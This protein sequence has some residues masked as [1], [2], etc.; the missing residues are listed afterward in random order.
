M[1]LDGA[2]QVAET[3]HMTSLFQLPSSLLIGVPIPEA[4]HAAGDELQLAVDQAVKESIENGVSRSGK[5]VTPWLLERVGQLTKGKAIISSESTFLCIRASIF[6][7]ER[8]LYFLTIDMALIKNNVK[9]GGEIALEYS[10]LIR[11][12]EKV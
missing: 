11:E 2:V 4:Y 10:K 6:F 12:G 8:L 5:L 1:R 3:I 9:V 7:A